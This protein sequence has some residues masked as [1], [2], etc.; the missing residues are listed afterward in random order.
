MPPKEIRNRQ[1]FYQFEILEK[2]ERF[3]EYGFT[4]VPKNGA[5]AVLV[6]VGG[7]REHGLVVAIDDRRYRLKGL[8]AGEV[9]L[10]DDQGQKVHLKRDGIYAETDGK[11]E[12]IAGSTARIVAPGGTT[13]ETPFLKVT[14]DI[15]DQS[16]GDGISMAQMRSIYN[17]HVHPENDNGGPTDGPSEAM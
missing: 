4:S 2:V 3:Q 9:A 13:L 7:S 6:A 15:I 8:A 16:S 17:A 12:A 5:E 14:G 11:I 10:Y 1:A